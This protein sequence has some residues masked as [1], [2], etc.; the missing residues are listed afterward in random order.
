VHQTGPWDHAADGV[1]QARLQLRADL[2]NAFNTKNYSGL[3]TNVSSGSFGRL[4][5]VSTRIMQVG[6]R[7]SF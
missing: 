1:G 7:L 3:Q 5:S 6:A 2:F 4:T